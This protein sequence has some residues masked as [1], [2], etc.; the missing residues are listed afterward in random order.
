M[1]PAEKAHGQRKDERSGTK[2][3]AIIRATREAG[4]Q[5]FTALNVR[6]PEC[7]E[8]RRSKIHRAHMKP[9]T[10]P[11]RSSRTEAT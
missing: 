8:H 2:Y 3:A 1:R 9:R 4:Y 5:R 6:C 11:P 7:G 10:V